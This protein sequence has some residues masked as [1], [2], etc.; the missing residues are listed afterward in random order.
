MDDIRTANARA[1]DSLRVTTKMNDNLRYEP[2]E[3]CPLLT[4]IGVGFQ[5]IMI[6]LTTMAA[7]RSSLPVGRP[8]C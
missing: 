1:Q 3:R 5:L 2:D 6:T 7:G 4:S 8:A